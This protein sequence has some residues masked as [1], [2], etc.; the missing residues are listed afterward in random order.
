MKNKYDKA[1]MSTAIVWA[2][3]SYCKRKQ[4]GAVLAENGRVIS[5]GY[6]GTI[7]GSENNCEDLFDKV[8][9]IKCN[10]TGYINNEKCKDCD[11]GIFSILKSKNTVVHAEA[12]AILYAAKKG[13]STNG[14]TL[15]VT[16]S[17][18]IDCA[19]MI[20]Q[21]GITEVIYLNNYKLNQGKEFLIENGVIVRQFIKI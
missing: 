13:N 20:I 16:L 6:N 10:G 4:V 21:A 2:Q 5:T 3:E 12:N 7:S 17:P 19:K 18:C 1:M 14:C 9:C 11:D 8:T 15:Y